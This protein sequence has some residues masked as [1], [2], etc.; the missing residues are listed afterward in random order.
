[1]FHDVLRNPVAATLFSLVGGRER[2]IGEMPQ[3][4]P[5]TLR[6][7]HWEDGRH[8]ASYGKVVYGAITG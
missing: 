8:P 7:P 3:N 4:L 5:V 2:K 1:M 6:E